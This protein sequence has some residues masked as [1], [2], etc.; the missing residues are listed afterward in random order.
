LRMRQGYVM[1]V[2]TLNEGAE[3]ES[4]SELVEGTSR[5]RARDNWAAICSSR[6]GAKATERVLARVLG[7]QGLSKLRFWLD[8][9][10]GRSKE[11]RGRGG[12][13][14]SRDGDAAKGR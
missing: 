2:E 8:L 6:D 5:R 13:G 4:E 9:D 10:V 14:E 11:G 7:S 1:I 3:S 12:G